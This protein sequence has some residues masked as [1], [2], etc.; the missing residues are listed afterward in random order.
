MTVRRGH[1]S[2]STLSS[3]PPSSHG[4][5]IVVYDSADSATEPVR[6]STSEARTS[7]V[8]WS[9]STLVTCVS[10]SARYSRLASTVR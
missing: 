6:L 1:R 3:G 10:H 4:R 2:A 8:T 5:N 9:P 7:R